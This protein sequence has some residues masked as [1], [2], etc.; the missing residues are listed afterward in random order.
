MKLVRMLAC[1]LV[2]P[3]ALSAENDDLHLRTAKSEKCERGPR[4]HHGRRG[5][6]GKKGPQGE[7]GETG[8][9][10]ARGAM[11][12]TGA[13]GPSFASLVFTANDAQTN[14]ISEL[15]SLNIG[16]SNATM[17]T[18]AIPKTSVNAGDATFTF[19]VPEDFVDND[20]ASQFVVHFVTDNSRTS[21]IAWPEI[22]YFFTIPDGTTPLVFSSL[23]SGVA[24]M[25]SGTFGQY[26]HY[27]AVF[28]LPSGVISANDL[29]V[30]DVTRITG[31][32]DTYAANIYLTSVEFRYASG[33]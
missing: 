27:D 4:G 28:A 29:A 16:L 22:G 18:A 12:A 9:R 7:K 24:V 3:M 6:R 26:N 17:V 10:G 15:T 23:A 5:P 13:A 33:P 11:G 31:G 1:L 32:E 19:N 21:G 25:G 14:G 2:I 20:G 8:A 30:F